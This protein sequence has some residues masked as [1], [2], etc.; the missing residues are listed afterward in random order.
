MVGIG[1]NRIQNDLN[2]KW[3]GLNRT[4]PD[5]KSP[6][7]AAKLIEPEETGLTQAEISLSRFEVGIF[8]SRVENN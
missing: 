2:W 5:R 7:P 3:N 1:L 6:E 8:L 4:G